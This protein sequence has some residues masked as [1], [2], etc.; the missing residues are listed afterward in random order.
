MLPAI[1]GDEF[2]VQLFSQ[3]L[4]FYRVSL[5][6]LGSIKEAI[7]RI[8]LPLRFLKRQITVSAMLLVD[9]VKTGKASAHMIAWRLPLRKTGY[10]TIN[11]FSAVLMPAAPPLSATVPTGR[12]LRPLKLNT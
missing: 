9:A 1:D 11:Y 5:G 12:S 2:S 6:H 10:A 8:Y 4:Q 7:N 3:S